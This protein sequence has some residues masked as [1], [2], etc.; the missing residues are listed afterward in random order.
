MI[1][2]CV[3]CA[4]PFEAVADVIGELELFA[5]ALP[6]VVSFAAGPNLDVEGKSTGHPSGFVIAFRDRAAL[7]TYADHPQHKALGARLVDATAAGPDGIVV[8]DLAT[9]EPSNPE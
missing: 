6:G 8:Y 2:H 1:L 7:A 4:A 9:G 3:F 5:V